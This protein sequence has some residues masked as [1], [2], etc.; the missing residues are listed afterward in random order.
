MS[1]CTRRWWIQGEYS[2]ASTGRKAKRPGRFVDQSVQDVL[3][4]TPKMQVTPE[5]VSAEGVANGTHRL[6]LWD[7]MGALA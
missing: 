5:D 1:L 3:K 6:D 2:L 7:P 4:Q